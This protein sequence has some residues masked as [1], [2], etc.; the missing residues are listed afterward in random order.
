MLFVLLSEKPLSCG[1]SGLG[2]LWLPCR[3]WAHM[4]RSVPLC[5][6]D[7]HSLCHS[8][9]AT[10]FSMWVNAHCVTLVFAVMGRDQ[11][12][13]LTMCLEACSFVKQYTVGRG[14][15]C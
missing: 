10:A 8:S 4:P 15:F 1:A 3:P 11:T 6:G 14:L 9:A 12:A 5:H 13:S 7:P 2:E